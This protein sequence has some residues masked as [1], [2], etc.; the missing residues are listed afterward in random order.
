MSNNVKEFVQWVLNDLSKVRAERSA[1]DVVIKQN[2]EAYFLMRG[3]NSTNDWV[4]RS[5]HTRTSK[6]ILDKFYA[7][8]TK[9]DFVLHKIRRG[10]MAIHKEGPSVKLIIFAA[11]GSHEDEEGGLGTIVFRLIGEDSMVEEY[12]NMIENRIEKENF[13]T[14]YDLIGFSP[15]NGHPKT[16]MSYLTDK[17]RL[18]ISEFY[19]TLKESIPDLIDGFEKSSQNGMLLMSEPGC[20]KS[21]LL[22]T[23][24][25][26]STCK[27]L[28][29]VN[30]DSLLDHPS[31]ITW[32]KERRNALIVM[33][34]TDRLL[35]SRDSGNSRMAALLNTIEGVLQPNVKFIF[36]TNLGSTKNID[37]ALLRPGRLYRQIKLGKLGYAEAMT[38]RRKIGYTAPLPNT[39]GEYTLA[40]ALNYDER[41]DMVLKTKMGF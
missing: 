1:F 40:E 14:V 38:A 9:N 24:F 35:V 13:T 10:C 22:R 28:Y 41:P 21:A 23:I 16:S 26:H 12:K 6:E 11:H 18:G 25:M 8:V 27:H 19:P 3:V 32:I 17:S 33:E 15:S 7:E 20:G 4:Q 5:M 30:D 2:V 29:L 34:D 36:S 37:E 39:M 31:F